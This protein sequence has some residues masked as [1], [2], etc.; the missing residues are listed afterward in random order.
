MN[1][2]SLY[3]FLINSEINFTQTKKLI[4]NIDKICIFLYTIYKKIIGKPVDAEGRLRTFETD[5]AIRSRRLWRIF[6]VNRPF[7]DGALESI[8]FM[9]K[10]P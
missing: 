4:N 1:V 8:S 6:Q 9:M 5:E 7:V 3:T 2:F 10:S